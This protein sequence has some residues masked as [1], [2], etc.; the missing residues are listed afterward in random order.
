MNT[1]LIPLSDRT[2][3]SIV[4]LKDGCRISLAEI[5]TNAQQLA[6]SL[7]NAKYHIV[8]CHDRH[9]FVIAFCS[10]LIRG[11]VNILP[12]NNQV[13]T[14]NE[15]HRSYTDTICIYDKPLAEEPSMPY[16]NFGDIL[17]NKTGTETKH[18]P[19]VDADH[20][21]AIAFT[22]GSTGKPKANPKKW[23][24][25]I[26]TAINE[27][28]RIIGEFEDRI[29]IV[30]TVPSQHMYGLELTLMMMLYGRCIV[31]SSHPFYPSQII[32]CL[33]KVPSPRLL[34]TTPI[35]LRSLLAENTNMPAVEKIVSATAPLSE[36]I[37]LDVEKTTGAV[38]EE[39]YGFTEA[40]ACATR[41][42]THTKIWRLMDGMWLS[43]G[44]DEIFISGKHL[45]GVIPL[46]DRLSLLSATE[47]ELHG[48]NDDMLKVGGKRAS[49][50]DLT[51]K[52]LSIDGVDDAVVFVLDKNTRVNTQRPAALLVT[53]I[54]KHKIYNTISKIIDP[55]FVPRPIRILA[56]L[57]RNENGKLQREVLLD[58]IKSGREKIPSRTDDS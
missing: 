9:A 50:E 24:S 10:A 36:E 45:D 52:I 35:H 54:D 40:G 46:Q 23:R 21:A 16:I 20:V 33:E 22:S 11:S 58:L 56:A 2:L 12:P 43:R 3:D 5:I 1:S 6:D 47:F 32:E 42:T 29:T 49:L 13:R 28:R 38:V 31:D 15:I 48:R 30:A 53:S 39:V 27:K 17:K 14:I 51:N 7:P 55:V 41:R 8:L 26:A 4:M 19:L 25:L 18:I 57:P 34:L 44:G 37:A